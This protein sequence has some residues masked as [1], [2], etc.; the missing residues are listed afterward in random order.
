MSDRDWPSAISEF[1]LLLADAACCG[2]ELTLWV[3]L[4]DELARQCVEWDDWISHWPGGEEGLDKSTFFLVHGV[5]SLSS[6]AYEHAGFYLHRAAEVAPESPLPLAYLGILHE[7]IG[8]PPDALAYYDASLEVSSQFFT[9][10]N[11]A[12]NLCHELGFYARAIG[13]YEKAL[14]LL[15]EP[16]NRAV[17]LNNLGNSFKAAGMPERAV[18]AYSE[19]LASDDSQPVVAF[20]LCETLLQVNRPQ[21]ARGILLKTLDDP[22]FD[23]WSQE[24]RTQAFALLARVCLATG[25][26]LEATFYAW[27]RIGGQ[28]KDEAAAGVDTF[29]K[30]LYASLISA[31]HETSAEALLAHV[32]RRLGYLD[33]AFL[34]AKRVVNSLSP[35][36]VYFGELGATCLLMGKNDVGLEALEEAQASAPENPSYFALRAMALWR[37]DPEQARVSLGEAIRIEPYVAQ[38]RCD[39]A[40]LE[41][42][43]GRTEIA[44]NRQT[45]ALLL[46]DEC[47]VLF[48]SHGPLLQRGYFHDLVERFSH[49][50]SDE[51]MINAANYAYLAGQGEIARA[52]LRKLLEK[53]P[54]SSQALFNYAWIVNQTV[55]VAQAA[56]LWRRALEQ[57]K[58]DSLTR[59]FA[60][61]SLLFCD[62]SA[63]QGV[64]Q[65][66]ERAVGGN[67]QDYLSRL[68]LAKL[69][70]P[71]REALVHLEAIAA[72]YG[73]LYSPWYWLG[74]AHFFRRE[75]D[76]ARP[77][78]EKSI[79]LN[80]KFPKSRS[81]LAQCYGQ[82]G[83]T[84]RK[85]VQNGICY[86]L[87]GHLHK[88][89]SELE[90]ALAEAPEDESARYFLIQAQS[91]LDA[92]R[93]PGA[94]ELL[95][96]LK[97]PERLP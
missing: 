19:A 77:F 11:S 16:G 42:N 69:M 91:G 79:R 37:S 75:W 54:D 10:L 6:Q 89:C 87:T 55:G 94:K 78:L 29:L 46:W 27:L 83:D 85:H 49:P 20:A 4:L 76:L 68:L 1:N 56:P 12:G 14:P 61:R 21:R 15:V 25:E 5:R 97:S 96:I 71:E 39:L 2:E 24:N 93:A 43:Q 38:H 62:A 63:K 47:P 41:M 72:A 40:W 33:A 9:V 66:L 22:S 26:H 88:A 65:E 28:V 90:R 13:Y 82:L 35:Q 51:E 23:E 34:H 48:A 32:S 70:E 44:R 74:Q 59:F 92:R 95:D 18:S 57:D 60:S 86:Y 81:L 31:P 53:F 84:L 45:E 73:G 30:A 36:A 7:A 8:S 64:I 50:T 17:V 67:P 3:E 80:P 52:H 58:S